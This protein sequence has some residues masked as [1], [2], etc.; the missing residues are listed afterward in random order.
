MKPL[1]V[2]FLRLLCLFVAI[3]SLLRADSDNAVPSSAP[4]TLVL[5]GRQDAFRTYVT[6][7]EGA[8]AFSKLRADFDRDYL[9]LP[10]PSEPFTYGDPSP[11]KRTSEIAD[12]WRDVQD[13][14]GLVSGV[15][16]A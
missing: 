5:A 2:Q 6:T 9:A 14:C 13:L 11:G 12:K 8:A 7:G 4:R 16:E 1:P 10:L 15:A 3:S